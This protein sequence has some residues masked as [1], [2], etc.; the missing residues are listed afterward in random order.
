[1]WIAREELPVMEQDEG[2]QTQTID[3]FRTKDLMLVPEFSPELRT[4]IASFSKI[5]PLRSV[6]VRCNIVVTNPGAMSGNVEQVVELDLHFACRVLAASPEQ[7]T[8]I[9][10]AIRSLD[11][12]IVRAIADQSLSADAFAPNDRV[13][14]ALWRHSASV[15]ILA[16]VIAL[17]IQECDP[18]EAFTCG[19]FHDIG[20]HFFHQSAPERFERIFDRAVAAGWQFEALETDEFGTDH[21]HVGPV[22]AR[23]LR[24]HEKL[25]SVIRIHHK[26]RNIKAH[27][28]SPDVR[29]LAVLVAIADDLVHRHLRPDGTMA[30][31]VVPAPENTSPLLPLAPSDLGQIWT[32]F[33]RFYDE[34]CVMLA[35]LPG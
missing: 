9:R 35:P 12:D 7:H 22:L 33:L 30:K 26:V 17:H 2:F 34:L 28:A 15:A 8:R 16:R 24:L 29:S 11:R 1:M 6:S 4:A 19:L 20:M 14:T 10:S 31:E 3:F 32:D 18:Q 5:K 13:A 27:E 25:A 23:Q 21:T